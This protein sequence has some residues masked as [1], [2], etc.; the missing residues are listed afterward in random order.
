MQRCSSRTLFLTSLCGAAF[1]GVCG[2]RPETFRSAEGTERRPHS[3]TGRRVSGL[4]GVCS[5]TAV[6]FGE[7]GCGESADVCMLILRKGQACLHGANQPLLSARRQSK[8]S[9]AFR[10]LVSKTLHLHAFVIVCVHLSFYHSIV[11]SSYFI[12]LFIYLLGNYT[13]MNILAD[14]DNR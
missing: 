7:E 11:Q 13:D 2:A 5:F 4:A 14:T 1:V 6:T 8:P 3:C 10:T 9:R 12:Y